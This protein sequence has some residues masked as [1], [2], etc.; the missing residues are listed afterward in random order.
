MEGEDAMPK[1]TITPLSETIGAEIG[2]VD[3]AKPVDAGTQEAL[4][5]ALAEHLALVFHDQSL[6]PDQYLAAAAAFGPPMQQHY[7]QH[8]MPEYPDIGLVWHRNGQAPAE[9][10]TLARAQAAE[11]RTRCS[12]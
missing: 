7:S 12:R 10:V 8:H 5:Q 11:A 2:G 9:R 6:T 1:I 3:L 4:S